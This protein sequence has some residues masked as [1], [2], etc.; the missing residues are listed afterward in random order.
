MSVSLCASNTHGRPILQSIEPVDRLHV[1]VLFSPAGDERCE[2]DESLII[3]AL[4]QMQLLLCAH[5]QC[6]LKR[7]DR[8]CVCACLSVCERES[9]SKITRGTGIVSFQE[10]LNWCSGVL[11]LSSNWNN[12][13]RELIRFSHL[14]SSQSFHPHLIF[15][16]FPL[17]PPPFLYLLPILLRPFSSLLSLLLTPPPFPL[18]P[19]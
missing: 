7:R 10:R 13:Q 4:G 17:N 18:S 3:N 5:R 8:W 19:L 14:L 16:F 1:L 12:Y 6:L 15:N 9:L 11:R 2:P